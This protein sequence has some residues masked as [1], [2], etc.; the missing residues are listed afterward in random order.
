[1]SLWSNFMIGRLRLSILISLHG[2][3]VRFDASYTH[4]L[5]SWI[6]RVASRAMSSTEWI[7][8]CVLPGAW[9][10]RHTPKYVVDP[11]LSRSLPWV[12]LW[13]WLKK[14]KRKKER[15]WT[16][17]NAKTAL[18]WKKKTLDIEAMLIISTLAC[19]TRVKR[20]KKRRIA[21]AFFA[22]WFE[23]RQILIGVRDSQ[24]K[25]PAAPSRPSKS[26]QQPMA[27]QRFSVLF[28]SIVVEANAPLALFVDGMV[29]VTTAERIFLPRKYSL[30]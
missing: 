24:S 12:S 16:E 13:C 6:S 15:K 25:A 28:R 20:E 18:W 11:F 10:L 9:T 19:I 3:G 23:I 1:M 26:H 27:A 7:T 29:L 4:F 2:A 30:F 5:F 8:R 21:S 22:L 17:I 14:R